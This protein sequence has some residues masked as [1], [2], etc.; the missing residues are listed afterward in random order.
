MSLHDEVIKIL[1]DKLAIG[2]LI[3]LAGFVLNRSIERFKS[4]QALRN[5]LAKQ[6]FAARIQRLERQLSEFYWPTYLR[7]QKDNAVWRRLLDKNLAPDDPLS[8]IGTKIETDF[9]LPNH[10]ELVSIIEAKLHLAEPSPELQR[11]L[12]QYIDHVAVYNAAIAAGF[13]DLHNTQRDL[14]PAWPEG[15]FEAIEE[16]TRELQSAYDKALLEQ[17]QD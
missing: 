4:A 13:T 6:R 2:V 14:L 7:L 17:Q 8:K 3:L 9:V 10:K 5:D 11:L 15:L 16:R 12:L 1:L